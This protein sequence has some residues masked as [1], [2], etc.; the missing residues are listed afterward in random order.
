ME[1]KVSSFG[2]RQTG[3]G[4][5][6]GEAAAAYGRILLAI[7]GADGQVTEPEFDWLVA[8]QRSFGVPEHVIDGYVG[9]D[10]QSADLDSLLDALDVDVDGW[11]PGPTLIYHAIQMAGADGV[12]ADAERAKV[13]AAARRLGVAEDIT[14]V[15]HHMVAAE[16]A[17]D[18]MRTALFHTYSSGH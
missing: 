9:F 15:L 14:D 6:S 16:A 3:L 13:A 11:R 1:I 2:R 10:H 4:A 5:V 7:V 18:A 8:H 17:L 12:Y